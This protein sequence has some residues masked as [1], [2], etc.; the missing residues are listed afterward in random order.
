MR[1]AQALPSDTSAYT[2]HALAG[3]ASGAVLSVASSPFELVKIRMQAASQAAVRPFASTL[4]CARALH[5]HQGTR[6]FFRGHSL[7]ANFVALSVGSAV[8]F[9][10]YALLSDTLVRWQQ[11]EPLSFAQ[12]MAMGGVTGIVYWCAIFPL[13]VA[14]SRI[15]QATVEPGPPRYRGVAHALHEIWRTAGARGLYRGI[16]VACIRGVPVNAVMLSVNA[17]VKAWM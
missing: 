9:S 14:K 5:R 3:F 6:G 8:Y 15:M 4:E 17:Q 12:S 10:T 7:Q 2:I 16:G 13:D 11:G 1:R